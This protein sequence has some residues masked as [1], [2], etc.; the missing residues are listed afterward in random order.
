MTIRT[1]RVGHAEAWNS[2]FLAALR[3]PL[4]RSGYALVANT[5]G[6]TLIGVGYWA[7]AAHLYSQ[8]AVGRSA[9]LVAALILVSSITQ[10]NLH[11]TL[12][13]FLPHANRRA[14]RLILYSYGATAIFALLGGAA[15]LLVLPRLNAQWEFAASTAPVAGMFIFAVVIWG[16]FALQDAALTGLQRAVVVP[17]ENIAY[18]GLKLVLLVAVASLM[19]S[20]GIFF[21]WIVPL[22]IC[23]PAVNWLIFRRYLPGRGSALE[24]SQVAARTVVRY[25]SVDYI[26]SLFSQAYANLPTLLVLSILGAAANGYFYIAWTIGSGLAA[27]ALNFSTSLLVEGAAAPHRLAELTRGILLRCMLVMGPGA[28][29]LILASRVVLSIYGSTYASHAV[30]LLDLLAISAIPRSLVLMALS[31]DRIAARVGRATLTQLALAM[32]VLGG[33]WALLRREGI[34]GVGFA[35]LGAHVVVAAA[36]LRTIAG[37]AARPGGQRERPVS[38]DPLPVA[39]WPVA[40]R[41]ATTGMGLLPLAAPRLLR[42]RSPG[43]HRTR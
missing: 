42:R 28:V 40:S 2:R 32:L 39:R 21:S 34:A 16:I 9:A 29:A 5:A 35:W 11:D 1:Q 6:T 30:T 10:L 19:P 41:H 38:A 8:Q 37:A 33:S 13:R 4:Y 3:N 27:I 31:L 23:V 17:A 26:G 20:T 36:R 43:R 25:A 22:A 14:A 12:P 24:V 7:V 15:F 18:G